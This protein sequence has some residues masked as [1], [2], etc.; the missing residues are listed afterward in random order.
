MPEDLL[1]L[2]YWRTFDISMPE[3]ERKLYFH[4]L[5]PSTNKGIWLLW[6]A[7]SQFRT[8]WKCSIHM[9]GNL[10]P[11]SHLDSG[12]GFRKPRNGLRRCMVCAQLL[13][14]IPGY[15]I[16]YP[17]PPSGSYIKKWST[18]LSAH[19]DMVNLVYST[20]IGLLISA[21][22]RMYRQL[23]GSKRNRTWRIACHYLSSLLNHFFSVWAEVAYILFTSLIAIFMSQLLTF[24]I[25]SESWVK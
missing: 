23:L 11:P 16:R 20:P 1:F 13:F 8:L 9:I 21:L 5:P 3:C 2:R 22:E 15:V 14:L 6:G 25:I 12:Y 19:S 7:S 4:A 18:L 24:A 10:A 17:P